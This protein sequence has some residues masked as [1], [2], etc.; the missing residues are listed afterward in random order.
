MFLEGRGGAKYLDSRRIV[1]KS[2][3]ITTNEVWSE[4][5]SYAHVPEC[6]YQ[7][8]GAEKSQQRIP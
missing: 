5:R 7:R 4:P 8:D 3:M 6:G 2:S 1:A